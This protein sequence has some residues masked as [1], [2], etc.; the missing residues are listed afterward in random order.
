[1]RAYSTHP[2]EEKAFFHP[3][4]LH[5]GH[6]AKSFALRETPSSLGAIAGHGVSSRPTGKGDDRKTGSTRGKAQT[7]AKRRLED[8]DSSDDE[9]RAKRGKEQSARNETEVRMY[10]AVRKAGRAVK[11]GGALG[12]FSK[13]N[14]RGRIGNG[15]YHVMESSEVERLVSGKR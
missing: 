13:S 15:E 6:V 4:T 2:V 14:G 10:A 9:P 12:E 7:A 8:G 11:S 5:L 3:K 1:M